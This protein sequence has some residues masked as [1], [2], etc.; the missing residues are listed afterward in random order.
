MARE[1]RE[2]WVITPPKMKGGIQWPIQLHREEQFARSIHEEH[3]IGRSHPV[4]QESDEA[5]LTYPLDKT[6]WSL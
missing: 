1:L 4:H 6:I 5:T 2:V 3:G